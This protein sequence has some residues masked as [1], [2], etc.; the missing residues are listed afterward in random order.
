M[1]LDLAPDLLKEVSLLARLA[2][3]AILSI[4][5]KAD[6]L[7]L[8][9]SQVEFKADK[10]PVTQA[11]KLAHE[12]IILGLAQLNKKYG[13]DAAIISEEDQAISDSRLEATTIWLVDPLD[14]TKE[15]MAHTH[16]FSVNIALIHENRPILGVIYIPYYDLLYYA[17]E[18]KGAFLE[19]KKD[20]P[21][22]Q[23]N[24]AK[25]DIHH[26]TFL[27]RVISSRRHGVLALESILR[28]LEAYHLSSLGSSWKLAKIAEDKADV[29]LR[30]GPTSEW[31]IAAGHL[32]LTE[33][34]GALS[35]LSGNQLSYNTKKS[36]TNPHFIAI[37]QPDL[38]KKICG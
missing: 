17:Q 4:Y 35:D 9:L 29:Y 33:A 14:G 32:I 7:V 20:T 1:Y 5:E 13:L 11:D 37:S 15:F 12:L 19:A 28:K 16:E 8:C 18:G 34:G 24:I 22:K 23:L 38:F 30:L 6:E 2:G 10:S 31:D 26:P 3:K 21:A 36:L 25:V 27:T